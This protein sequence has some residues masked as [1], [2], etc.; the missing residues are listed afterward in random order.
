LY[1]PDG[2]TILLDDR[3]V[4]AQSLHRYRQLFSAF[5]SDDHLFDA[6]IWPDQLNSQHEDK[7][8]AHARAE[9]LLRRLDLSHKVR[10]DRGALST[11]ALSQGQRKRL[12]LANILL[13]DRSVLL[14]D[15]WAA[16]QEPRWKAI[17]Y[18][19]LLPELRSR[20]K[21]VVVV[22]HDDRY[23]A[24]ADRLLKLEHGTVVQ[25]SHDSLEH[26][27]R[28]MDRAAEDSLPIPAN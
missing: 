24:V 4:S 14:L 10:L 13:E 1:T 17:F 7:D 6:L 8:A 25:F 22:S 5:F 16:D 21:C 12:A 28:G 3:P 11:T 23:Y 20:G 27:A 15:E 18:N 19:E 26:L 9:L 2:G